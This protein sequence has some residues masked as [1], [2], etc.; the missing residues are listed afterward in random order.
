MQETKGPRLPSRNPALPIAKGKSKLMEEKKYVRSSKLS[1]TDLTLN[2]KQA[3]QEIKWHLP[4]ES[5]QLLTDSVKNYSRI[6][7]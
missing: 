4:V 5:K 7:E 3:L 2:F 6:A 1:G